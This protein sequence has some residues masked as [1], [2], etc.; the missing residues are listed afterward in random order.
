MNESKEIHDSMSPSVLSRRTSATSQIQISSNGTSTPTTNIF[1]LQQQQQQ[2]QP[3]DENLLISTQFAE[4][5]QQNELLAKE[6]R[7]F[8]SF[9][10]RNAQILAETT[11][12]KPKVKAK[13]NI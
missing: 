8:D 7:L 13:R 11:E 12:N 5:M 6:N 4:I 9:L 10:Q 3:I 2:Q 1:Q